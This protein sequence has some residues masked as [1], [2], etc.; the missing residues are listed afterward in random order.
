[1]AAPAPA[2][3]DH[4]T[5]SNYRELR[6]VARHY[7]LDVDFGRSV[8]EGYARITVEAAAPGGAAALVLDTRGLTVDR[9]EQLPGGEA[10]EFDLG[11]AHPALGAPLSV[12]LPSPLPP[13][14]R[15][16]VGVRF[17][18]A[19]D[20]SAL[21]FL[22]PSMTAGG[23]HPY[24]FSQC[25][26]IHARSF[27]PCQDTPAVKAPYTAAVR[28]ARPLT[29]LMSAVPAAAGEE[30]GEGLPGVDGPGGAAAGGGETSVF[31]FSQRVP[32]PSY[33]LALAAGQQPPPP[34]TH[35][36]P[37]EAIAGPYV[38]GRYDLLLL[39]PSFPYGGMENPCLTFVTPTLLAG[40]RSLTNVVAHEIAHSWT[41]NLVTNASWEDF[42]LNEGWTVFLE[43]KILGRLQGEAALQF[44][45]ARGA[46]QLAEEVARI[47]P[48][49]N[50]TRLVPDLSGG[51]DP[52]DAFSRIPY[53]KGFYFLYYIQ[54][55]VGGP[56]AFEPFVK[57][58]LQHFAFK[59]LT[60]A[61]F[62]SF[63][64]AYFKDCPALE[65]VDWDAWLYAPGM[66]P[67]SNAYDASL[68]A[69]ADALATKWHTAD[70]MG[71][72]ADP[73][74][75]AGP[76]DI[77]GWGSDQLVAFLAKL[78]ELRSLT[79]LHPRA[80]RA[81]AA[82]Y[83]FDAAVNCEVKCEWLKLCIS[84]GDEAALPLASDF[85]ASVGRMKFLRP[86]YRALRRSKKGAEVAGRA[87]EANA[88][89]YHPIA[90]K[91][92]AADLAAQ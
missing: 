23:R 39:P 9:A 30:A 18:T 67:A 65:G 47:G 10:L 25:Q 36:R 90:R 33:L 82:L 56:E 74:A 35:A 1:M 48:N 51:G 92:V 43:R 62:L 64:R 44:A 52:D 29:A 19:P 42:W 34:Q 40:D 31:Y 50:F 32:V 2:A 4:T 49:H 37:G 61:E 41:G 60:T 6:E 13:G 59:T 71:I 75:G 55:L 87:F 81:M 15:A 91:M 5:R 69:A 88:A 46:M 28:V 53:E 85:L 16:Q 78:S 79:P 12:R 86:L 66:P 24:L 17:R 58:Y 22:E 80:T 21:Q 38:W 57:D 77:E 73:P 54:Q 11:E 8:I 45:A 27:V 26:A 7:E 72:G 76:G 84:A 3:V 63:L 20:A 14:G 89:R 68:A 83:G 70:V